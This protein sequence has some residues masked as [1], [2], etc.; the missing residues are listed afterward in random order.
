[1]RY[2]DEGILRACYLSTCNLIRTGAHKHYRPK[3][4]G[5]RLLGTF[6]AALSSGLVLSGAAQAQTGTPAA[7][8]SCAV[9]QSVVERVT[10]H[11]ARSM[12]LVWPM[13]M[14]RLM[15]HSLILDIALIRLFQAIMRLL[16]IIQFL[17]MIECM[18]FP[19]GRMREGLLM[20]MNCGPS[21]LRWTTRRHRARL[22]H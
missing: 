22:Q 9:A 21:I 14:S 13:S 2:L 7:A 11:S 3:L 4:S 1:M 6:V 16:I 20:M 15:D 12:C 5:A 18:H 8:P 17:L 10:Y 19:S